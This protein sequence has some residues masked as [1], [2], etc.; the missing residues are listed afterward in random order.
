MN[1]NVINAIR[2]IGKADAYLLSSVQ[3]VAYAT[4]FSGDCSQLLVTAN[5]AYFFTDFRYVEQARIE[6]QNAEVVMTGGGDRLSKINGF[7]SENAIH[8]LGIEKDDVTVKV[9]EGYQGTF[10]PYYSYI[11]VAEDLLALRMVKTEEELVKIKKAARANEVALNELLP[12]I[13]PGVSELDIRAELE[14]R[15]QRQGMDLAFPTIV[16]AGLNSALPHATPSAYKL[17]EGDLLTIDFGCRYQG[18][19]SD[20]TRTFGIGNIDGQRKKI[21]DIVKHA[22]ESAAAAAVPGADTLTVDAV[23]RD[24]IAENGYGEYY[25]HGT[26]HGVGRFIHELPVLNPRASS[27]LGENMVYTVEPGIYVPGIGGVR[28]EDMHIGGLGSVYT[29]SK[30]LILL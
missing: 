1:K 4:N 23:A 7:L 13:K 9:F 15:M 26:G 6:V 18:Y 24:I 10:E 2:N 29:F 11:D 3:N 17:C 28:I 16:A 25:D 21:Y 30:E 8:S 19:C 22:Q 20:M 14:Y 27:L 12:F 5:G